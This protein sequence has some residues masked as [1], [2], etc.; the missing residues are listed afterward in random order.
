M[1]NLL[2]GWTENL[3]RFS[4]NVNRTSAAAPGD[5]VSTLR[6]GHAVMEPGNRLSPADDHILRLRCHRDP[7]K[8]VCR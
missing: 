1:P 8:Q 2:W 6:A 3:V 5:L 4:G 7:V